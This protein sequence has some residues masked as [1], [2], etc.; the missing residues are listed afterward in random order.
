MP[1]RTQNSVRQPR[2]LLL[3]SPPNVQT[4]RQ[5]RALLLLSPPNVQTVR[6]PQAL[7]LLRQV[8][9]LDQAGVVAVRVP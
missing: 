4:V 6:Q 3:L 2:A 5:P 9:S 8:R 7:P 1:P